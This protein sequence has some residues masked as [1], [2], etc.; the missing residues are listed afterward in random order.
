[1]KVNSLGGGSRDSMIIRESQELVN[2]VRPEISF[3]TQLNQ[4][5]RENL[6]EELS[7]LLEDVDRAAEKLRE[8]K[9]IP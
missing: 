8:E 3:K 5:R 9:T 2:V 1:M 7:Q 6:N 4:V